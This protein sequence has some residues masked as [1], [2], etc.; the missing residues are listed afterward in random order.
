MFTI[1]AREICE[2]FNVSYKQRSGKAFSGVLDYL[3]KFEEKER[4]KR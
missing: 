1:S 2:E 4:E 3:R